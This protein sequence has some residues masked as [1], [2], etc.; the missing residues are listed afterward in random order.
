MIWDDVYLKTEYWLV[1]YIEKIQTCADVEFKNFKSIIFLIPNNDF[2]A[3]VLT[4]NIKEIKGILK[5]I[6]LKIKYT[7]SDYA[8]SYH[9]YIN[10][11][12]NHFS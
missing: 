3:N 8:F 11:K 2:E 10:Q 12:Y 7:V 4:E 1:F 9:A 6:N 5:K